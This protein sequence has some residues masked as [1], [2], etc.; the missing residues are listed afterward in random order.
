MKKKITVS[1]LVLYQ[2]RHSGPSIDRAR[3]IRSLQKIK[4]RGRWSAE[5]S[6]QRY[7][8]HARLSHTEA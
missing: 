3:G 7:E 6:V 8:R 1:E 4:R 2:A 5:S